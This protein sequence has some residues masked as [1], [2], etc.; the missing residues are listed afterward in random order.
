MLQVEDTGQYGHQVVSLT[1]RVNPT[2]CV[3][4]PVLSSSISDYFDPTVESSQVEAESLH[5]LEH[6]KEEHIAHTARVK[7]DNWVVLGE[8]IG[9][10]VQEEATGTHSDLLAAAHSW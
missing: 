6:L 7:V 10:L 5:D 3:L 9:N 1:K 8:V 4:W 2:G